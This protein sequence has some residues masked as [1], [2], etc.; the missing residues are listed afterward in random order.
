MVPPGRPPRFV[1]YPFESP[2]PPRASNRY[3][4][5]GDQFMPTYEYVCD[6]CDHRLE[7]LQS[8]SEPPL[9]K[10]PSC[11]KKKLRR[12]FGTGIA[13]LFKGSGFYETDYKRGDTYKSAAKADAEPAAKPEAK[14]DTPAPSANGAA[15]ANGS[16]NGT[17]G[18]SGGKKGKGAAAKAEG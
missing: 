6:A 1:G 10:C 15:S 7:E 11:K 12:L 16:A 17:A 2:D 18:G 3:R 8:F 9:T 13:V 4:F 14:A 5:P